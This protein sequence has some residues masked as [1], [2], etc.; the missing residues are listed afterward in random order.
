[1]SELNKIYFPNLNS[2][3]GIAAVMVII[4]HLQGDSKTL[5][6]FENFGGL[7]V[8][9]FFILSGFLIAYLLLMEKE[10]FFNIN[11]KDFY[12]R[13]MLRIWPLYFLILFFVYA[14]VPIVFTHY[15]NGEINRFSIKSLLMNIFFLTNITLIMKLTPL[16][17]RVIWSIGIEEQ[18]YLMLPWIMKIREKQRLIIILGIIFFFPLC[19]LCL[20]LYEKFT[21]SE[22]LQIISSIITVTRFDCMA[23]GVLFGILSFSK[24]INLGNFHITYIFFIKRNVQFIIYILLFFSVVITLLIPSLFNIT[25]YVILPWLFAICIINLATNDKSIIKIENK[26]FNYL[27]KISF[28]L[29][30][31]HEIVI[32][33]LLPLIMPLIKDFNFVVKNFIVYLFVFTLTIILSHF[34]Y[35]YYENQFLKLKRKVSYLAT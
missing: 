32:F 33:F 12:F 5:F 10:K 3:R 26:I 18:F 25:N 24:Q 8:T 7:G 34:S 14:I 19:K 11:I 9:I 17:I 4:S 27:G 13:R 21:G 6:A 31:I 1:M 20:V 23:I 15:Y 22:S 28:G 16:V 29:Y 2:L 30:L 35:Y